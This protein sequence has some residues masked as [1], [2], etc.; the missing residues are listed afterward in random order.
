MGV[1]KTSLGEKSGKPPIRDQYS[2]FRCMMGAEGSLW[3]SKNKDVIVLGWP[4][5]TSHNR[6]LEETDVP[7]LEYRLEEGGT[8]CDEHLGRYKA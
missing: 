6:M 8:A 5:Q 4:L 7:N 2:F 1:G 3:L